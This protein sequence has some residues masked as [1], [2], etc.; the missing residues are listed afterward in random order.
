MTTTTTQRYVS[1]VLLLLG[2]AFL[3]F[4]LLILLFSSFKPN[5]EVYAFPFR[6]FPERWTIA[7]YFSAW[8]SN[9]DRYAWNSVVTSAIPTLT[10]IVFGILAAYALAKMSFLGKGLI[11]K[12][13]VLMMLVPLD[14]LVVPMFQLFKSLQLLDTL[15][16]ILIPG[17][18][19]AFGVFLMRQ[20]MVQIPDELIEAARI[21]GCGLAGIIVRVVLPNIKPGIAVLGITTFLSNWNAFTWPFIITSGDTNKTLAVGLASMVTS[22]NN[23]NPGA[24][25]AGGVIMIVPVFGLFVLFQKS[26]TQVYLT[27]G[28][29]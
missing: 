14:I 7:N 6:F 28:I 2:I 22:I 4:P 26:I 19:S 25:L 9:L 20:F 1:F 17:L 10:S 5:V 13:I 29:K 21:D 15:S 3:A 16:G 23:F 12:F 27:A 18:M 24:L 11:L 8:S